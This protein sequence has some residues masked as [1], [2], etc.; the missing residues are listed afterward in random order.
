[1]YIT[2]STKNTYWCAKNTHFTELIF[3]KDDIISKQ[4]FINLKI[5]GAHGVYY[6]TG[7]LAKLDNNIYRYLG[8]NDNQIQLYGNRI[9][10]AEIESL[11][12]SHEG[13]KNA[14]VLDFKNILHTGATESLC[15][16]GK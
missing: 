9:E 4:K 3:Y 15:V 2:A 11:L 12:V 8:R 16:C 1:M 10:P 14:A 5:D 6:R 7:D 13:I